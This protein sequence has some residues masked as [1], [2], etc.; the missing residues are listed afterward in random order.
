MQGKLILIPITKEFLKEEQSVIITY[1]GGKVVVV[2]IIDKII[3]EEYVHLCGYCSEFNHKISELGILVVQ[4]KI[5]IPPNS[6]DSLR[7]EEGEIPIEYIPLTYGQ[8]N[9]ILE[10]NLLNTIVKFQIK[11]LVKGIW[12]YNLL[13][14]EWSDN[15]TKKAEI[16]FEDINITYTETEVQKLVLAAWHSGWNSCNEKRGDMPDTFWSE[17]KKIKY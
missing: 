17:N 10:R 3:N 8:Y 1:E 13:P 16:L 9:K 5:Y 15:N 12:K 4:K 2:E 6:T 11:Y 14:S 7:L